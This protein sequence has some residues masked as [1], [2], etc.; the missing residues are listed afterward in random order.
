[1][2][3]RRSLTPMGTFSNVPYILNAAIEKKI[4]IQILDGSFH[5]II[6]V[7]ILPSQEALCHSERPKGVKNPQELEPIR[8]KLLGDPS[9]SLS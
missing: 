8:L 2:C 4:A 5:K 9:R 6:Q 1:L 3:S 7:D